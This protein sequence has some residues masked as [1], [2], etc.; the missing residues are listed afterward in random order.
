MNE[1]IKELRKTLQLTQEKF[2][3]RIGVKRNTVATYEM[4]RSTPSDAAVS[5]ICREFGVNEA[6]LRSGEGEMFTPKSRDEEIA[7]FVDRALAGRPDSF[8]HRFVAMLSRL[9]EDGWELLEKMA[10]ELFAAEQ[11]R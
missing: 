9:D 7:A 5:L 11:E 6:W 3:A 8:K 2:A 4:G 10:R 1:R